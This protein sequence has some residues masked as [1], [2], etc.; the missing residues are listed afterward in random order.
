MARAALEDDWPRTV[1]EF[2]ACTRANPSGGGS[3]GAAAPDDALDEAH[4]HQ[5]GRVPSA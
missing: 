3:S 5:R 1:A 4:H 2:E